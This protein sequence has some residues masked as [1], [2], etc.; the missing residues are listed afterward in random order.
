MQIIILL[1]AK[2]IWDTQ[3]LLETLAEEIAL[4]AHKLALVPESEEFKPDFLCTVEIGK[5]FARL[6][7]VS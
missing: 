2:C 4:E 5:N 1:E 6:K 7:V 3:A